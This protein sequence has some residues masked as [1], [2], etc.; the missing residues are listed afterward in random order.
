[1]SDGSEQDGPKRDDFVEIDADELSPDAL[2][3]L[4]E[5]FVSR[6]GTDYGRVERS[7]EEKCEDV[8]RQLRTG[9]ACIVF[10]T[11]L[12]RVN[13]VLARDLATSAGE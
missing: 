12:E 10:D 2:R 8:A 1:M 5:E 4:I 7:F 9:D 3:G 11:K 13:L 6:E